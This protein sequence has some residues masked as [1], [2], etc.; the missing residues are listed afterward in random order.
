MKYTEQAVL[1][2]PSQYR[3]IPAALF[4]IVLE[5][6]GHGSNYHDPRETGRCPL[7]KEAKIPMKQN[8]V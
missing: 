5:M 1:A 4:E 8:R 6:V 3:Y 7:T 2:I